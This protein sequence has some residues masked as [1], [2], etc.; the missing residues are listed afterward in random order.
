MTV[1]RAELLGIRAD[2]ASV[3]GRLNEL[4]APD[5][6]PDDLTPLP[7]TKAIE[8]VLDNSGR[9]LTPVE[10]WKVLHDGGRTDRKDLVQVATNNLAHRGRIEQLGDGRYCS[11]RP[12]H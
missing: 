5:P 6:A 11:K 7:R 2:L 10:I 3:L 8:W 12:G 4:L 9:S 1:N